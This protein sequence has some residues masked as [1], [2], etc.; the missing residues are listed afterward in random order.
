[1]KIVV[2]DDIHNAF[3]DLEPIKQLQ[4]RAEVECY[5]EAL[6]P[7]NRKERLKGV[8]AVI[9]IRERS[10][11]DAAWFADAPDLKFVS[12]TGRSRPHIDHAAAT[13]A[14]VLIAEG[15]SAKYSPSTGELAWGLIIGI[16]RHIPQSDAA[17][18]RGEWYT[19]YGISLGGKTIGLVG[20]GRI[21]SQMAKVA[22]AFDMKVLTW[23]RNMTQERAAQHGATAVSLKDL[24]RQSDVVSVHL[25][26]NEGTTGLITGDLMRLMKPTAYFVN[27]ARAGVTDEKALVEILQQRKIA[28]AGL[29][30]FSQEPLPADH[31]LLK[32]DNVVLTAHAGYPSDSGYDSFAEGAV[33]NLLA[34]MDGKLQN[35]VNPEAAEVKK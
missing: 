34:W 6:T 12:Q 7:A 27:T 25:A 16:M 30:V 10:I 32:L 29:D 15:S 18:R 24:M 26:L 21:G 22:N 20:L 1:M 5:T 8:D 13:K 35:V 33:S 23:S 28:G 9:T 14:G 2:L 4:Q 3:K 31:P 11:L 17:M 19:P